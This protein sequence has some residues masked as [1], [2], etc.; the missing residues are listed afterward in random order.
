MS[1]VHVCPHVLHPGQMVGKSRVPPT[2][3]GSVVGESLGQEV[4]SH[5]HRRF[6]AGPASGQFPV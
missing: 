6:T 1:T 3:A 2:G 5:V 4:G